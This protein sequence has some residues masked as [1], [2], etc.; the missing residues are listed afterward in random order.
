MCWFHNAHPLKKNKPNNNLEG[1]LT[2]ISESAELQENG[3]IGLGKT[4]T[5]RKNIKNCLES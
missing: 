3:A 4:L 2:E 5:S 1:F